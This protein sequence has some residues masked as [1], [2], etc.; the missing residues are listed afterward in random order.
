MPELLVLEVVTADLDRPALGLKLTADRLEIADQLALLCVDADHR[1]TSLDRCGDRLIDVRK[2]RV[3]IG[4][5][6]AL[7]RLLVR[8]QAV[9]LG[10]QQ[11]EHG[12]LDNVVTHLP[13]RLRELRAAL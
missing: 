12:A 3:A 13:Q 10:L 2:L 1:L 7:A 9:P 5:L 4:M 6:S 11:P 8:L